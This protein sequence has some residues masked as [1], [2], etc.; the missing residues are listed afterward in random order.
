MKKS[1]RI[2]LTL[3]LAF[4]MVLSL[5]AC[6]SDCELGK[7]TFEDV[8][9]QSATCTQEGNI[10]YKHCTACDGYFDENGKAITK[11]QTVEPALG[12]NISEHAAVAPTCTQDGNII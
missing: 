2:L 4:V 8:S 7:H 11:E 5:T 6:A 10:A 1:F 12:H 3:V 9:A